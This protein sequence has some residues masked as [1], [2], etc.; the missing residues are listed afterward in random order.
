MNLSEKKSKIK[1][2]QKKHNKPNT[3]TSSRCTSGPS[4]ERGGR[5]VSAAGDAVLRRAD[6]ALGVD[7]TDV[8]ADKG[9]SADAGAGVVG[10]DRF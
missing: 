8:S 9:A 5:N 10:A 4:P 2:K 7:A 3:R 1:R 6:G